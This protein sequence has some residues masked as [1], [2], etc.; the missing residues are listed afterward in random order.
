MREITADAVRA[1]REERGCGM[2]EAKRI[3]TKRILSEA[4]AEAQTV[5]DL[6]PIILKLIDMA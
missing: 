6:R 2:I 1:M 3:L 4:C 5:D